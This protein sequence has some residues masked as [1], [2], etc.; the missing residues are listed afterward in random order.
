MWVRTKTRSDL[1]EEASDLKESEMVQRHKREGER[2]RHK[3][4]PLSRV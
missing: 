3:F 2:D 1:K 4:E